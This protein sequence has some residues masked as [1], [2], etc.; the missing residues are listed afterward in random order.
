[1]QKKN[2]KN[3]INAVVLMTDGKETMGGSK[4]DLLAYLRTVQKE[5][6]KSGLQIKVFCI[7]YGSDADMRVLT[8]I[9]DATLGKA[10]T[11]STDTIKKLYKLLSTYF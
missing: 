6:D 2:D 10:L 11:G 1:M 3:S 4:S 5:G 9:A 8:D 7:A